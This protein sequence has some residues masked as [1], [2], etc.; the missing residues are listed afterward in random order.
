M[1]TNRPSNLQRTQ[2]DPRIPEVA[3]S[4]SGPT[5]VKLTP[6][7]RIEHY[8]LIRELGRGGMGQVFLARDTRLGRRVAMKFLVSSSPKFTERF[9]VEAKVTAAAHHENIVV[10]HDV[11]KYG[12]LPYM[13]LEYV[14]GTT[15]SRM[16]EGKR[17]PVGRVIE[18]IAPVV[19]ALVRA[20]DANIVHRDLKPDN[21]IVNQSGT[22]KVLDFGIAKLFAEG[23]PTVADAARPGG[24]VGTLPYMSP[25]QL[26]TD[27]V[28]H[29]SDLWAVGIIMYEMLAG[30][31]PL[32]PLT[33]G[34][35]FGAAASE[36]P[37]P[38][39]ADDV[40]GLPD[41]IVQIVARCLAKKKAA[42]YATASELLSDLEPLLASRTGRHLVADESPYPGLNAF[43]ETDADRFFGRSQDIAGA[44]AKLR[45]QPIVAVIGPSGAGK[46][47]FVRAGVVPALKASGDAWECIIVRPG[48]QPLAA[49]ATAL[50][51]LRDSRDSG[52]QPAGD[53]IARLR[54]E[55]GF[56]GTQLRARARKRRSQ[57]LLFV[58]QHE[59]LY[60]L[61]P[62]ADER[63]AFTAC[64]IGA[65]DDTSGP[66]RVVVAM[67]SDFLDRAAEDRYFV[68]ELA[69]GLVF[70]QPP[71][72]AG[73]EAALAGPLETLGYSFEPGIVASMLETLEA[74]PGPLPLLQFTAAKLWEQRDRQ[75]RVLTREAYERMGG[76]AG[77][78]ATH[79][80]EVIGTLSSDDQKLVKVVFQ[81]LV[82][83]E[84][85]RAIVDQA[86]LRELGG[87]VDRI[88]G[89]LVSS[90]LIVVHSTAVELVHESLI[91]D[92]PTLRRWL[93]ENQEDA[94]FLAQLRAAAQQWDQRQRVEGLL[95]RNEAMEEARL[96]RS[97][98]QKVLPVREQAFLDAVFELANRA[99]RARRRIVV[100]AFAILCALVAA[101]AVALIMIRDAEK[102]ANER[103]TENAKLLVE[104]KNAKATADVAHQSEQKAWSEREAALNEK[105]EQEKKINALKQTADN[106]VKQQNEAVVAA[107]TA[108]RAAQTASKAAEQAKAALDAEQ[109]R[110]AEQQKKK[111]AQTGK[112]ADGPLR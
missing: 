82:T 106:A 3:A 12:N 61:V 95:W 25:E 69:R 23:A 39:L 27:E 43:Q 86:E 71:N 64:L 18:L 29:R 17:M 14:E 21:I 35:I 38:S 76:V 60:T 110:K 79:A 26:G 78:L 98:S 80:D 74:T 109:K 108:S 24:V 51:N 56:L 49:L 84:R 50:E 83:P 44:V 57:I 11:G 87:D 92:W 68:E 5:A 22:V 63:R 85:T 2:I 52:P 31:H 70:L 91:K 47:S 16:M 45:E 62:D 9:V 13:V 81:R 46:S 15:L 103:A 112:L 19:K 55:P 59:E 75:R 99:Q 90:R 65:A 41:R 89:V 104:A 58:D 105:L 88:V 1:S 93:D 100:G 4:A 111:E 30:K 48:R 6:G 37:M 67:R 107:K 8:E 102:R 7:L 20:H 42:R 34:V 54:A 73:L 66:L 97:R 33:Q 96:W 10:I 72:R 40:A 94:I 101:A 28:D 36:D 77:A 53:P 32:E